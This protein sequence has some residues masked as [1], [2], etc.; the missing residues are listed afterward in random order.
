VIRIESGFQ[1]GAAG[2]VE[3]QLEA[4]GVAGGKL[5]GEIRRF[6]IDRFVDA[7]LLLSICF[8]SK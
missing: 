6:V 5:R 4:V 8:E 3:E 2:V 7:N 1:H